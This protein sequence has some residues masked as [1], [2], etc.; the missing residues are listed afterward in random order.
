M[1]HVQKLW[2]CYERG[3]DIEASLPTV[4]VEEEELSPLSE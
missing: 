3:E 4:D 2:E 1:K